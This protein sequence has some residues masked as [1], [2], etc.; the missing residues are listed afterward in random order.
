MTTDAAPKPS[1]SSS[2]SDSDSGRDGWTLGF[3]D[4]APPSSLLRHR[5]PS[6]LGGRPAWLDPVHLPPD[7]VCRVTGAPLDFLAQLYAP[8]ESSP[9]AFHRTLFVF[10]SPAGGRL[11]EPGAVRAFRCQLPRANAFY[12]DTPAEANAPP[13]PAP[14]P[15][16]PDRWGMAAAE[17]EIAAGR[18]P[19]PLADGGRLF[20]EAELVVGGD[21]GGSSS[22]DEDCTDAHTSSSAASL[23]A[24]LKAAAA[25]V[26]G[27]PTI[28]VEGGN[29]DAAMAQASDD[30]DDDDNEATADFM[31]ALEA[32]VHPDAAAMADFAALVAPAPDQVLR[33]RRDAGAR[34]VWPRAAPTPPPPPPCA[35]CGSPRVFEV[36]LLPQLLNFLGVDAD[37]ASSP[38]W[39]AAAVYTCAASCGE[40]GGY[41]EEWV[42]VQPGD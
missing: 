4:P 21:G 23:M 13:P 35:A 39:A 3:V 19:P 22:E 17:A 12:G 28:V 41:H 38:D 33:Y 42:W 32:G 40:G 10:V 9:S 27:G 11:G 24:K 30:D 5:F 31:S 7:L 20:A 29:G 26:P 37:A 1:P 6:K 2:D 34:P 18:P 8:L 16:V 25:A 36:Q 15:A 14:P